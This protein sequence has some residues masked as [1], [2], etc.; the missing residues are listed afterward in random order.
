MRLRDA[1]APAGYR[2]G[3]VGVDGVIRRADG[4]GASGD[5]GV[6]GARRA[7]L[8]GR[9]AGSVDAVV[10]GGN[11][12]PAAPDGDPVL[13]LDAFGAAALSVPCR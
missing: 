12:D 6:T 4:D 10:R 13:G 8:K 5:S 7:V 3:A 9:A 2:Q 11:A 1:D